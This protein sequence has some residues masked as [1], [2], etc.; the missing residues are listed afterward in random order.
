VGGV[1]HVHPDE[2]APLAGV[3]DDLLDVGPA[4]F[5]VEGEAEARELYGDA[6][7]EVVLVQGVDDLL[8][9]LELARGVGLA[10]GALP[11]R[12]MVATQPSRFRPRTVLTASSSVSP[13]M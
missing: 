6:A 4:Q 1:L 11:R 8:V 2:A 9:V 13:A 7:R 3:L 5:L 10:L 12:S